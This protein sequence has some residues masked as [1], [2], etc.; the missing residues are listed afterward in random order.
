[1]KLKIEPIYKSINMKKK[2]LISR[3]FKV[4]VSTSLDDIL[5]FHNNKQKICEVTKALIK[6]LC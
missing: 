3:K 5:T 6:L 4:D 1:M 2:S